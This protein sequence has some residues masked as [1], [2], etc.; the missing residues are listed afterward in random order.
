[1]YAVDVFLDNKSSR[2]V[3]SIWEQLSSSGIDSSLKNTDGLAPHITLAI[4]EDIDEDKFIARM[5]EFRSKL[6]VIDT[7]FDALGAFPTTGACFLTPV[8]TEVLLDYHKEYY[9]FFKEFEESAR[10]YYLP[11]KWNPHCS[12]A[13]G[14]SKQKLKEV[15]NF[16][17]DI[18]E[19]FEASFDGIALYKVEMENG[20]FTDSI[21]LF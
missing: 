10:S 17:V 21:R 6:K 7:R 18:Y 1:M 2:Y 5:K 15:F 19:P 14:L 12:L 3:T 4:Y 20:K 13:M 11:G 16:V 9:D 8:I